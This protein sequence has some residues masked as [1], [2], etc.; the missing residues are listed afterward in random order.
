MF[1]KSHEDLEKVSPS[2]QVMSSRRSPKTRRSK[3]WIV[4]AWERGVAPQESDNSNGLA[5]R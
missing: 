1:K 3:V 2:P 5:R 4:S